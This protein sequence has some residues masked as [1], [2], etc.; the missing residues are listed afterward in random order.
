[1]KLLSVSFLLILL[2]RVFLLSA[3]SESADKPIPEKTPQSVSSP[4]NK[5]TQASEPTEERQEQERSA[6]KTQALAPKP[7]PANDTA[8]SEY[9]QRHIDIQEQIADYT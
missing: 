4:E 5:K 2:S 9:E 3:A 7:S 1:M 8:Q 6:P